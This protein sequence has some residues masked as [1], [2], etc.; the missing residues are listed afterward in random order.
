M[1]IRE[2]EVILGVV[3]EDEG[4]WVEV[5]CGRAAVAKV[6]DWWMCAA[7]R[8]EAEQSRAR[9]PRGVRPARRDADAP[10]ESTTR[11]ASRGAA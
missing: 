4:L 2:C 7:C 1:V 8:D 11:R 10:P 5:P 3:D 6:H 9:R